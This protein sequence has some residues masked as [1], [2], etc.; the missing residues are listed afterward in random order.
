MS[1]VVYF[2]D[3]YYNLF[4][5]IMRPKKYFE[6]DVTKGR[7]DHLI[8]HRIPWL[9]LGL[10]GGILSTV[11]ISKYES[12]LSSDIRIAFFITIIVY[13]SDAVG[14]QTETLYVRALS[15]GKVINFKKYI[16]RESI[17]GLGLGLISG[18]IM[19]LFASFWLKSPDIGIAV[20]LTMI[21]NLTIAPILAI[22][23]P[24]ILYKEHADP[25]LGAG[26]I[27]TILQDLVS[28]MVYFLVATLLIL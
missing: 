11:I 23:I 3:I 6:E 1:N 24:N 28:L 2:V 22:A 4:M 9:L 14:T 15:S 13:L 27:A 8:E 18:F 21:I 19:A 5:K 16:F 12:V 10:L 20:G 25:A 26:P 17:I 7:I